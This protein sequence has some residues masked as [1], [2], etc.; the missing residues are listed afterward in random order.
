MKHTLCVFLF[1][2]A[3][4]ASK[5]QSDTIAAHT[6]KLIG[7]KVPAYQST[8]IDGKLIDSSYFVGK[9]TILSF[10]A[11]VAHPAFRS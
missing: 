1:I 9:I 10:L 8:T 5:S 3:S 4:L 2:L 11:S 7:K 6:L